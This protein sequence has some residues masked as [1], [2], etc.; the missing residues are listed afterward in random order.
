MPPPHDLWQWLDGGPGLAMAAIA[1][2]SIGCYLA[3]V[4][5]GATTKSR[6]RY[7]PYANGTMF[8]NVAMLSSRN[9]P[10]LVVQAIKE[11]QSAVVRL[12]LPLPG[13]YVL[14]GE[15]TTQVGAVVNF[16]LPSSS[17][18]FECR[19]PQTSTAQDLAGQVVK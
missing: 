5:A 16:E 6:R 17:L 3:I 19:N 9:Y 7:P 12:S 1:I 15:S 10:L 14:V 4:R 8:Q 11:A 2:V 13:T 18:T